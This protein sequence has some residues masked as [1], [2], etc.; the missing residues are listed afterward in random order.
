MY[1]MG[2]NV[3]QSQPQ[4][5][6]APVAAPAPAP[7]LAQ[8]QQ[9]QQQ[10]QQVPAPQYQ[11]RPSWTEA[12]Q[13]LKVQPNPA[14]NRKPFLQQYAER[15][16]ALKTDRVQRMTTQ[17]LLDK[18]EARGAVIPTLFLYDYEQYDG[19]PQPQPQLHD[20]SHYTSA[21][22]L[23]VPETEDADNA[24]NNST[25]NTPAFLNNLVEI[26]TKKID[27]RIQKI[28]ATTAPVKS[29]TAVTTKRAATAAPP[30]KWQLNAL[31]QALE[32]TGGAPLEKSYWEETG[33]SVED[34]QRLAPFAGFHAVVL[35]NYV[36]F[37]PVQQAT[38]STEKMRS[39]AVDSFARIQEQKISRLDLEPPSSRPERPQR[40]TRRTAST[41]RARTPG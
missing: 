12:A 29:A 9:S 4:F 34:L 13:L 27:E 32:D 16:L 7:V 38:K 2:N 20:Y 39:L 36:H 18:L 25:M 15:I 41:Q 24:N 40:T 33:W 31:K 22:Q 17:D 37:L 21:R 19:A 8:P 26:I 10:Q 3:P 35:D 30:S 23:P 14:Y 5:R 6:T 1:Y 28:S 11:K